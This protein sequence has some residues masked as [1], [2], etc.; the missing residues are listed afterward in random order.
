MCHLCRN[1]YHVGRD[2][3]KQCMDSMYAVAMQYCAAKLSGALPPSCT[4]TFQC[5]FMYPGT[6]AVPYTPLYDL[7]PPPCLPLHSYGKQSAASLYCPQSPWDF[8]SLRLPPPIPIVEPSFYRPQSPQ[9]SQ[10]DNSL[11]L[12]MYHQV[13]FPFFCP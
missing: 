4:T 2:L 10:G 6:S 11:S 1:I 13:E 9:G 12:T 8:L 7:P 3:E 5:P